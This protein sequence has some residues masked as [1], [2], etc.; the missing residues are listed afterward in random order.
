MIDKLNRNIDYL[1]ISVTDRCNLRCTYCMPEE[2]VP[3]IRHED[4]V[5]FDEIIR[6]CRV[7]AKLGIKKIK[8]TGGEPL[9]RKGIV[10]LIRQI[11]DIDGIEEITMTSNGVLLNEMVHDLKDAGVSAVNVS[12]DTLDRENFAKITRRDKMDEVIKG[13]KESTKLGIKTKINCLVIKEHN[14]NELCDIATFARDYNIQVRFIEL[15]PIGCGK[16]FTGIPNEEVLKMLEEK[17]GEFEVVNEKIGNGPAKYYKNKDFKGYI[18]FISAIS[19]EFCEE[20]NRVRLTSNGFLKL[21]LHYNKGI[22]LKDPLRNGISDDEL[23]DKIYK[24]IYNKPIHHEFYKYDSVDVEE[25]NMVEIG[26]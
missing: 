8:I 4:I 21:C 13:I 12:L 25:K 3:E 5:S 23:Q 22:D 16:Q 1:R 2:G 15:M 19:N 20:C 7:V 9:V 17:F 24:A 11:N 10:E 26:G 18:G 6:I 14:Y